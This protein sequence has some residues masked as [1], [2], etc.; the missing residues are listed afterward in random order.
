MNENSLKIPEEESADVNRASTDNTK[1]KINRTQRNNYI[2]NIKFSLSIRGR[3]YRLPLKCYPSKISCT[4]PIPHI[5]QM[6]DR[7]M[8]Q[9]RLQ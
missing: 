8:F 4:F 2:Q 7:S 6:A 9:L 1:A 5:C 3:I